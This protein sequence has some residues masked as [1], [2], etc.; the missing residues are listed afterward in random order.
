M[1]GRDHTL[2]AG[3]AG[4]RLRAKPVPDL[5]LQPLKSVRLGCVSLFKEE[6]HMGTPHPVQLRAGDAGVSVP[7]IFRRHGCIRS[8]VHDERRAG[9][10]LEI[11]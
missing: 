3:L 10:L 7:C 6:R 4:L 2:S 11:Q 1:P 5:A 9:D 8:A